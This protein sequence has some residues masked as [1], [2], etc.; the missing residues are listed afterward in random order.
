MADTIVDLKAR[1]VWDSRGRPTVEVDIFTESGLAGRSS[2][3]AGVSL[4]SK[5]ALELRD[6]GSAFGGKGVSKAV[7]I[8]NDEVRT[9][10]LGCSVLDQK[11]VDDRIA[12]VDGTANKSRIGSN[13]AIATSVAVLK[14]AAHVSDSPLWSYLLPSGQEPRMPLPH[15]GIFGGGEHAKGTTNIQQFMVVPVGANSISDS[16]DWCSEVNRCAGETKKRL[17]ALSGLADDGGHWPCFR[18]DEEGIEETLRTIE[19]AGFSAGRDLSVAIDIAAEHFFENGLYELSGHSK[20]L[21][22]GAMVELVEGWIDQYSIFSVEDPF[23]EDDWDSF[24][25]LTASRGG[26]CQVLGDDLFATQSARIQAGAAEG[27]ANAVLHKPNQV[28]TISEVLAARDAA[29]EAGLTVVVAARSGDTE[30]VYIPH[31]AVGLGADQVKLGGFSRSER[32]AKYN[33]LF[34]IEESLRRSTAG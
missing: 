31:L 20:P 3:C 33:E 9:A 5:E 15:V 7:D 34:R 4:G 17:G 27:L 12:K 30:D 10:L 32:L 13:V 19:A 21:E 11:E 6:G 29:R 25:R 8:A 22:P 24:A 14:A 2:A 26:K 1:R 18:S 23:G 16:L 28:G